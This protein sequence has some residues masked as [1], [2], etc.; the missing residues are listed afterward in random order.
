MSKYLPIPAVF[1]LLITLGCQTNPK[2]DSL[3][4]EHDAY[5]YTVACQVHENKRWKL[6]IS[7]MNEARASCAKEHSWTNP[8]HPKEK[9]RLI[10][11]IL[12]ARLCVNMLV[13]HGGLS[14]P[15]GNLLKADMEELAGQISVKHEAEITASGMSHVIHYNCIPYP[16]GWAAWV[17][18]RCRMTDLERLAVQKGY[19]PVVSAAV[20][21]TTDDL[22]QT[23]ES[24]EAIAEAPTQRQEVEELREQAK[25]YVAKIRSDLPAC[26]AAADD[27]ALAGK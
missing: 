9:R 19:N 22:I 13:E 6:I 18:L 15:E 7:I 23:L 3:E 17:R 24:E 10:G 16:R 27:T 26:H 20:L 2:I 4:N 1:V 5:D 12:I 14:A 11:E 21:K 8:I 25:T